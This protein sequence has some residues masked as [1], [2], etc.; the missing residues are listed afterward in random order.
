MCV[1]NI[2]S[3][4]KI[5]RFVEFCLLWLPVVDFFV[6]AVVL[7]VKENDPLGWVSVLLLMFFFPPKT[8]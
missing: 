6:L 1:L 4:L 8:H 3:V 7:V 5:R 2:G